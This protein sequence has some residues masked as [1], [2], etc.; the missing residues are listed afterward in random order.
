MSI[1]IASKDTTRDFEI[2]DRFIQNKAKYLRLERSESKFNKNIIFG[3]NKSPQI[4][5]KTLVSKNR[6]TWRLKKPLSNEKI[7]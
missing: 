4:S 7:V 2:Q 3:Q 5:F 1:R 6:T